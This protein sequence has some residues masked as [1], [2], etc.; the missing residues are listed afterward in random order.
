MFVC[1]GD[2]EGWEDVEEEEGEGEGEGVP[3]ESEEAGHEVRRHF[4]NFFNFN[5]YMSLV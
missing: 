1:V 3:M 5:C 2:D 4:F